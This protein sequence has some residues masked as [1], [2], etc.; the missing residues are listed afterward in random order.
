MALA[1]TQ[2]RSSI[3]PMTFQTPCGCAMCY[4]ME[5]GIF[6]VNYL[7]LVIVEEITIIYKSIL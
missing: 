7:N 3:E 5:A 6:D 2:F 4:A 1:I